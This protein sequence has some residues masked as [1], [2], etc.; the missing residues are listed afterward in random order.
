MGNIGED[1]PHLTTDDAVVDQ[2]QFLSFISFIYFI[3]LQQPEN[4]EN[5]N[6]PDLVQAS[7]KKWGGG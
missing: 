6:D 3:I 5:R 7:P 1:Y 4:W 2:L